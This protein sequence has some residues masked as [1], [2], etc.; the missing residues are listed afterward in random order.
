MKENL[1]LFDSLK[2]YKTMAPS[3]GSS[4]LDAAQQHLRESQEEPIV[5]FESALRRLNEEQSR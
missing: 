5:D 1:P 4:A 2:T 3:T